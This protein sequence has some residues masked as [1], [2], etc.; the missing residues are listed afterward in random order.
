MNMRWEEMD[1]H[2]VIKREDLSKHPIEE[3]EP[4]EVVT[5]KRRKRVRKLTLRQA[6]AQAS[7][8]G[9]A[10][11]GA[12]VVADGS[13]IL[14]FG[15]PKAAKPNGQDVETAEDIRRLI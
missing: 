4:W 6:L 15:E 10:V 3:I 13:V 11:S 1:W 14:E 2:A 12:T 8:A 9:L 7:K 5:R